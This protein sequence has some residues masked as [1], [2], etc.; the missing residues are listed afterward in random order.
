MELTQEQKLALRLKQVLSEAGLH[1]IRVYVTP[2]KEVVWWV[3][4]TDLP[5]G[6]NVVNFNKEEKA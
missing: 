3:V 6:E 4:R 1:E 5:E 2:A